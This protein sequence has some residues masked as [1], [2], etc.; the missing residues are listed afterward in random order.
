MK[1]RRPNKYRNLYKSVHGEDSIPDG[2]VIH[3]ID[4]CCDNDVIDNLIAMPERLHNKMHSHSHNHGVD[5]DRKQI[6][7][8][9]EK[10]LKLK[11]SL[12]YN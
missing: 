11:D 10:Y 8:L 1:K 2:R 9:I 6:E 3:H 5:Y 4:G 7:N 12:C